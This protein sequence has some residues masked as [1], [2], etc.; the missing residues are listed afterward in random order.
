MVHVQAEEMAVWKLDAGS[1]YARR[2]LVSTL[3]WR[4]Y[5]VPDQKVRGEPVPQNAM[6]THSLTG[7]FGG[8]GR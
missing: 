4:Q 1:L 5:R 3:E 6:S 2:E 8:V 7:V